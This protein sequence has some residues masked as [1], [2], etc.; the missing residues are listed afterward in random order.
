MS[1]LDRAGSPSQTAGRQTFRHLTSRPTS[2]RTVLGGAGVAALALGSGIV[3]TGCSQGPSDSGQ[4]PAKEAPPAGPVTVP[5]SE[6]A[7]GSGK[8][9]GAFIVTQPAAGEFKAFSNICPH[10]GCAVSLFKDGQMVC[11]CHGSEFALADGAR[12]AGPAK[13][14]LTA[15]KVTDSGDSLQVSPQS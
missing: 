15:A 12:T 10:Q 2:R 3:L 11:P 5:K 1:A 4:A 7:V 14:G 9:S 6:V 8:V 13:T